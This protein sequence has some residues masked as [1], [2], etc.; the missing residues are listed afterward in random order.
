MHAISRNKN[1]AFSTSPYQRECISQFSINFTEKILCD[2][3]SV[4]KENIGCT[5]HCTCA[6]IGGNGN[7]TNQ[8]F[9]RVR[10]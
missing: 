6:V 9:Q 8:T 7:H 5:V 4:F 2:F 10:W 3:L 1:T